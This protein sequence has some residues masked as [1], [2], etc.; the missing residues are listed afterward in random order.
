MWTSE[1]FAARV[2]Q[3]GLRSKNDVTDF[4]ERQI[5]MKNGEKLI[6]MLL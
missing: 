1:Y 2:K 5:L 4:K 3:A 6:I